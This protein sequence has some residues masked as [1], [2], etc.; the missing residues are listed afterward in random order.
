MTMPTTPRAADSANP[1][2]A[3]GVG[4][5]VQIYMGGDA[6]VIERDPDDRLAWIV[7]DDASGIVASVPYYAIRFVYLPDA[8]RLD[9]E[10][11]I[12]T[13]GGDLVPPPGAVCPFIRVRPFNG[14]RASE[15]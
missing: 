14:M 2:G 8:T 6:V 1:N 3:I 11:W 4:A 10:R 13:Y 12:A 15:Y 9:A 5:R 7:Q